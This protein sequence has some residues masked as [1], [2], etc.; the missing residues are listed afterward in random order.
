MELHSDDL[1]GSHDNREW[2]CD[3]ALHIRLDRTRVGRYVDET[4]RALIIRHDGCRRSVE[5]ARQRHASA[6]ARPPGSIGIRQGYS[7]DDR[8]AR[9]D[10]RRGDC[11]H[12]CSECDRNG[13]LYD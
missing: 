12:A 7:A 13:D 1:L 9:R 11:R 4:E 10:T 5:G 6:F 2:S 8:R 3:E